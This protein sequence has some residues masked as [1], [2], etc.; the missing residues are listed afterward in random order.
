[1][2]SLLECANTTPNLRQTTCWHSMNRWLHT[3]FKPLAWN[4]SVQIE[5]CVLCH[6]QITFDRE[7][8]DNGDF[9]QNFPKDTSAWWQV[10]VDQTIWPEG[11]RFGDWSSGGW[12]P[13]GLLPCCGGTR[14]HYREKLSLFHHFL[15]I[16]INH[17]NT[18]FAQKSSFEVLCFRRICLEELCKTW[19]V[20]PK[21]GQ[22]GYGQHIDS[23]GV[24][25]HF[26]RWCTN[27]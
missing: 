27:K 9:N 3:D 10:Q 26:S 2:F 7:C 14:V 5:D 12:P 18:L 11:V 20:G 19:Q 4:Q 22:M 6:L 8:L 13:F 25:W 21:E 16:Y 24:A 23:G 17:C 15:T 1:M